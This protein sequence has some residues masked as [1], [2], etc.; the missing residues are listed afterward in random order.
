MVQNRSAGS[1][2]DALPFFAVHL[3]KGVINHVD[4]AI[5]PDEDDWMRYVVDNILIVLLVVGIHAP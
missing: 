1:A 4:P 5:P 2:D 3:E